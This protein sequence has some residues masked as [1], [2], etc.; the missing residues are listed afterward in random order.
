MQL[1]GTVALVTGGAKRVG[2][3]IVLELAAGGCDV[4]IHYRT[5]HNEAERLATEVADLGRRAVAIR[6]D[7]SDPTCCAGIVEETV[8]RLG[9]LDILVNN[10]AIFPGHGSD[11]VNEFDPDLWERIHRINLLAPMALSRFAKGY[12]ESRGSGRIINLCDA[13]SDRPWPTHLGYFASK[14]GLVALTKGLARA[15]AP[16]IQVNGVAPG[17]AVFPDDY[18]EETRRKLTDVVPLKREGSPKDVARAVRFLVEHGD[19]IT[20]E[21]MAVDGGRSLQ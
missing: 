15:M 8:S 2:R 6:A 7:L 4:G 3:A 21:I 9:R 1:E 10:A 5:S 19:Y 20:G 14:A 12:L 18:D 11:G 16:G 13:A 17:I